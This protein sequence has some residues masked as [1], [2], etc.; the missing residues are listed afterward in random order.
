MNKSRSVHFSSVDITGGFWKNRQDMNADTTIHAVRKRFE[1][2]GRFAAYEGHWREGMPHKPYFLLTGDV[3]KWLESAAY[4]LKKGRCAELESVCDAVIRLIARNQFPDGYFNMWLMQT[5]PTQRWTNRDWHE[6]YA[7]GHLIEAAVAYYEATGKQLLLQ[8]ACKAAD[9][10]AQVFVEEQSAAFFTPGHEEIEL[11]LVKLYRCTG[12]EKYLALSRHF[13]NERG[14]HG[15]EKIPAGYGRFNDWNGRYDQTHAP[16]R[17]QDTAEGHAVRGVYLYSAM[18]DLAWED[19]DEALLAAC[20]KIFDNIM[21]RRMYITGGIGSTYRCEGFTIDYDL[22]NLTA[23]TESC[24]AIG[25]MLFARRMLTIDPQGKYADVIEQVLYNGF[26]SST[27]L[28]GASFFYENPLEVDPRQTG[29]EKFALEP[30]RMPINQRVSVFHVS[31]CPP[32][33]TR[34][35]ASLGDYLYTHTDDTVYIHQYMHSGAEISLPGGTVTVLQETDYPVSG[36]IRV[37]VTGGAARQIALRIPGWCEGWTLTCG[38][39]PVPFTLRDGYAFVDRPD[40]ELCLTL[41]MSPCAVEANPNVQD[42]AGRIAIRRG[43]VVYCLEGVDNGSNLRDVHIDLTQPITVGD[44]SFCGI[45]VLTAQGWRRS[46]DFG[47][48]L[49]RRLQN[50]RVPQALHFIPYFAFANRGQ[51][52]MIIW[53]LP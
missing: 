34:T 42:D 41:D 31:C 21:N 38:D 16:V 6:L 19:E 29:K 45:P 47:P 4:L 14:Q 39:Q 51:T 9:H 2:T 17:E 12:E 18:A 3:E 43:P 37:R 15:E 22:P 23:Y 35:M 44:T 24:A 48:A 30:T 53:I 8:C 32:N 52:E 25:L 13:L 20:R 49:Y 50:S 36:S 1:D 40:G 27:G 10:V 5:N 11:A 28:D 7:I 46:P 33:I 26:L